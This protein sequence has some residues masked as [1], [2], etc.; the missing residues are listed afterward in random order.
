M[1]SDPIGLQGGINTY[2]YVSADP[3]RKIDPSG[4][5]EQCTTGLGLLGGL[6][7]ST[8]LRHEYHCW[9]NSDGRRTCRGFGRDPNSDP[10]KA[11]I[12]PVGGKI[13]KDTDNKS[14]NKESCTPDDKDKCM[15]KCVAEEWDNVGNN[16]P[17]YAWYAPN[18]QQCK[19]VKQTVY[20]KC[21]QKCKPPSTPPPEFNWGY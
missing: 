15:D 18:G 5:L 6:G 1:E 7:T 11:I 17:S 21:A 3:V 14:N 12:G 10:L 19:A 8:P 16:L 9:T 2:G 20:Q 13:L 4:L